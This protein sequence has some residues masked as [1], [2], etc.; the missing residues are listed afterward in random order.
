MQVPPPRDESELLQRLRALPG[1]PLGDIAAS[2]ALPPPPADPR[3]SKG[4][5]GALLERALGATGASKAVP[6]FPALGIEL[7]TVPVDAGGAPLESTFVSTFDPSASDLSWQASAVRRKLAR[8]A[9]VAVGADGA[10]PLAD[11]RCG[12][13][14]LW[15][16]SGE[17][18]AMLRDDYEEI[19][20]LAAEGYLERVTAHRG[21]A[22]QLRPKGRGGGDLR[23]SLDEEGAPVRVPPRAFYLRRSFTRKILCK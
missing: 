1:R 2:L 19:A 14:L 7:K 17:E 15:S 21:A 3:R 10:T 11:R 4:W 22:L 9:W 23:W 5:A 18:E 8:V 6:D 12:A 20:D 16:P 13:V